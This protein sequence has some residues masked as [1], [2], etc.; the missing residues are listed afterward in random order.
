MKQAEFYLNLLRQVSRD[1]S[2]WR[3]A[4][5]QIGEAGAGPWGYLGWFGA[6]FAGFC[7]ICPA[8]RAGCAWIKRMFVAFLLQQGV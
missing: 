1:R 6:D 8:M 4:W 2:G 7:P 3:H 5:G